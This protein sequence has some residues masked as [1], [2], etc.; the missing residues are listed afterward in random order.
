MAK[1]ELLFSVTKKDFEVQT[2]RS[3]GKGGQHQNKT[4]SGVRIIHK[5][6]GAVGESREHRE[7]PRNKK[8]AFERCVNSMKFKMWHAQKCKEL[9][10]G[11]T[12]AQK[13]EE[14]MIPENLKIEGKDE[15]GRWVEL[16]TD[17]ANNDK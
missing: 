15:A 7:Q 10:E 16:S 12:L 3:G 14:S 5:D 8:A 17:S 1:K 11:K 6:S 2:F 13:I 4:D 9:L